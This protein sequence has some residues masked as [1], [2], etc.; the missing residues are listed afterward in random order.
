M[1]S[2]FT[3]GS[4]KERATQKRRLRKTDGFA[5]PLKGTTVASLLSLLGTDQ[6]GKPAEE[7]SPEERNSN[8]I[9]V[10]PSEGRG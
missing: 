1:V 7:I 10:F 9:V 5:L 3:M 6:S 8:M 4:S 2:L